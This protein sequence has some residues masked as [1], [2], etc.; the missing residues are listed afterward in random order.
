MQT[1]QQLIHSPCAVAV[2]ERGLKRPAVES[3]DKHD[4]GEKKSK[5]KK[6][7]KEKKDDAVDGDA[8]SESDSAAA[9]GM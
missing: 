6:K 1:W 8:T 3:E 4:D 9:I 5:K 2:V 7:N